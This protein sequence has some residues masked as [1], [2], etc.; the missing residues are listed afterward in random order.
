M[1]E[2][3]DGYTVIMIVAAMAAALLDYCATNIMKH[4]LD[5]KLITITNLA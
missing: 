2:I 5:V 3:F 1:M 4:L